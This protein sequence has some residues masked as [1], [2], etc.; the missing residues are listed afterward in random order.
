[1]VAVSIL[2]STITGAQPPC[3]RA[4][5]TPGAIFERNIQ[6]TFAEPIKVKKAMRGSAT[7]CSATFNSHGTKEHHSLGRPA[8]YKIFTKAS[9]ERGVSSAGF[10]NTGQPTATA[11]MT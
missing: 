11:G 1:M 9:Q 6:P 5:R 10:T 7:N 3:S 2:V 8:S 4:Q